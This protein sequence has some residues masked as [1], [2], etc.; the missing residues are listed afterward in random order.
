VVCGVV[1]LRAC[2]PGGL[3]PWSCLQ[4]V[5]SAAVVA[6]AL[7]AVAAVRCWRFGRWCCARF[8]RG[9]TRSAA[10]QLHG[11]IVLNSQRSREITHDQ[12]KCQAVFSRAT[13]VQIF[14][15]SAVV[16]AAPSADAWGREPHMRSDKQ[17]QQR[18]AHS[19]NGT[20]SPGSNARWGGQA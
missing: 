2:C 3:H 19:A 6:D 14:A 17:Q 12:V 1:P 15:W 20:S 11:V 13:C 5:H 9:S 4:D 8:T 16:C 7:P 10:R 18:K